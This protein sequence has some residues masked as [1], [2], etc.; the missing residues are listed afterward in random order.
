MGLWTT[1][2]LPR[3]LNRAMATD[4]ERA[5]RARVCAD[6]HGDVLEIGFGSGLNLEHLPPAVTSVAVVEPSDV[7]MK[8]AASRVAQS[9]VPVRRVGVDAQGIDAPDAS[10]DTVLSTWSLCTIPDPAAALAEIRRVL[11]PG[12]TFHFAEHGRSDD[13][14]VQTWQ[15]RIEPVHRRIAGG[16]HLTRDIDR[17]VTDNGF[18]LDRLERYYAEKAPR[19]WGAMYE[20]QARPA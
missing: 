16:C 18:V 12:G 14:G 19:P 10:A 9:R 2:L 1:Q 11:R 15:H 8:L 7:A 3:L 5:I 20:G 13:S 17:L 6:L 4:V